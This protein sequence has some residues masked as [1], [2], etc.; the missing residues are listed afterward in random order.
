MAFSGKNFIGS[1][2]VASGTDYLQ[3]RVASSGESLPEKFFAA[4][5]SEVDEAMQLAAKAFPTYSQLPPAKIAEFLNAIADEIM[6]LGDALVERASLESGLPN[7][8][9]VGERGR[10]VN[11]LKMFA[12]VVSEGSWVEATID[13]AQPDRK[14]FPKADIR[15]MLVPVGPVVVFGASNFPLAFSTAGGDTASALAAGNP[16]VVKAHPSHPGT[17][18]MVASAILKAAEKTGMPDGVFSHLHDPGFEVGQQLVMHELTESVAFTGSFRGGKALFDMANRREK[19]IPVFAE[20][21]SINPVILLPGTLEKRG[22]EIAKTM[23]GSVT[24]GVGQFCTNPGVMLVQKG[25]SSDQFMTNLQHAI[26]ET[27]PATMLNAGIHQSYQK[28]MAAALAE[29]GVSLHGQSATEGGDFQARPTIA[30][31]AAS[32]FIENPNLREE[33]FGPYSLVVQC[34]NDEELAA[35]IAGMEGQLTATIF[36]EPEDLATYSVSIHQLMQ[37]VGR[38]IFNNVPTGV[39]VCSSMHHGGPFPATTDSR[40]TSV[41]TAAIKRFVRPLCFQNWPDAVLPAALKKTNPLGIWR[42]VDNDWTK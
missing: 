11:Q 33:V 22:E 26:A 40:F 34:E 20:M 5:S 4:T 7:G 8:R 24:L 18:E 14:P 2:A 42:L 6:D 3:S 25:A 19:P 38:I 23:A 13:T 17:S 36:G 35:A 21:G 30:T 27:T 31:V 10:T 16:V 32:T 1:K 15:K 28:H 12:Q 41:G 29:K 39:E 9:F 37:K